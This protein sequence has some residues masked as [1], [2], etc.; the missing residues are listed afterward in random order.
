MSCKKNYENV[1]KKTN[2]YKT[3]LLN[4][5]SLTLSKFFGYKELYRFEAVNEPSR[6]TIPNKS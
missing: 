3:I 5:G 2:S 6:N 1:L 4:D